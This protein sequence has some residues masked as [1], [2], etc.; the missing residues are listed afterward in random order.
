M[1]G[2]FWFS[3]TK[4]TF[5]L[6]FCKLADFKEFLGRTADFT[7]IRREKTMI[8]YQLSLIGNIRLS[9]RKI[10]TF[11][12][13]CKLAYFNFR[14]MRC[15]FDNIS[16]MVY[17]QDISW[18]LIF[19]CIFSMIYPKIVFCWWFL[20]ITKKKPCPLFL[21]TWHTFSKSPIKISLPNFNFNL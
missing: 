15:L 21:K 7:K 19:T 1:I 13:F 12:I 18:K 4:I 11:L 8:W 5:F 2:N 14:K 16:C 3:F 17:H 20:I 10:I 6:I 9:L